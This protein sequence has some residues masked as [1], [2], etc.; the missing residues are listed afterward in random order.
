MEIQAPQPGQRVRM[1]RC[2]DPDTD[3]RPDA[4]GTV[5]GVDADGTVHVAWDSPPGRPPGE[6][7]TMEMTIG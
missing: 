5:T 3:L 4:L 6:D 7:A 2:S 1:I